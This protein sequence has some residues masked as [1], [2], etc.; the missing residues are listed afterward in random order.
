MIHKENTGKNKSEKIKLLSQGAYGCV[1]HPGST[2]RGNI[3]SNKFV[4][5]IQADSPN[6]KKE[7]ELG[8][9]IKKIKHYK[10]HFAP[11]LDSCPVSIGSI[12]NDEIKKCDITNDTNRKYVSNK[13]SFIGNKTLGEYLVELYESSPESSHKSFFKMIFQTHIDLLDSIRMLS[14]INI[15]HMDLKDDN[16]MMNDKNKPIIIDFGLSMDAMNLV[17]E[18]EIKKVFW[19][20]EDYM[21]W[22]FDI[23]TIN[24]I[25]QSDNSW[26]STIGENDIP[27]LCNIVIDR[28]E[29]LHMKFGDKS[30]FEEKE[31]QEYKTVMIEYMK[32][33]INQS[34]RTVIDA[35]L[36]F[37]KTWDTYSLSYIYLYLIKVTLVYKVE[38]PFIHSYIGLLKKNILSTPD[39]RFDA[40]TMKKELLNISQNINKADI[41]KIHDTIHTHSSQ[42]GFFDFIRDEHAKHSLHLLQKKN[43]LV[44]T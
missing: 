10:D 37:T 20:F 1:F 18:Q 26:D 38:N 17:S 23:I 16:I 5:K 21:P 41:D 34:W 2:C 19:I 28:C 39:K 3:E 35:L 30:V 27:L 22:C 33:F 40:I 15:V 11:I 44:K 36:K 29:L 7:I 9:K 25:T 12:D 13:I 24:S 43:K 6:N 4:R 8:K 31:I 42:A 14:E 32:T